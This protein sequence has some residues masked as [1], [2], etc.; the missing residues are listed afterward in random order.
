M[1]NNST[2]YQIEIL[3]ESFHFEQKKFEQTALV[4]TYIANKLV[5]EIKYGFVTK[6]EIYI[7]CRILNE[8]NLIKH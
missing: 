8:R 1:E 7:Q 5:S 6:E 3:N 2:T 4:K